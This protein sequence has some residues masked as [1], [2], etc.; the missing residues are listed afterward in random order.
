MISWLVK[1]H[2]RFGRSFTVNRTLSL[3]FFLLHT[4]LS[5]CSGLDEKLAWKLK[6]KFW[7]LPQSEFFRF[8]MSVEV[9][10][11]WEIMLDVGWNNLSEKRSYCVRSADVLEVTIGYCTTALLRWKA[12]EGNL[13][14]IAKMVN[15]DS[16]HLCLYKEEITVCILQEGL[17]YTMTVQSPGSRAL[18]SRVAHFVRPTQPM[19]FLFLLYKI[20]HPESLTCPHCP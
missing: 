4:E 5:A 16:Q 8:R 1:I 18:Q 17:L 6:V 2:V 11:A 12:T 20:R 15:T 13:Q 7:G 3:Y 10:G 9:C 14:C 19:G